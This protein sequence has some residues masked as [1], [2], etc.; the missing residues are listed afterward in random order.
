MRCCIGQAAGGL[1]RQLHN[2]GFVVQLKD[3]SISV[4]GNVCATKKFNA[5]SQLIRDRAT[6]L[7]LQRREKAVSRLQTYLREKKS[8]KESVRTAYSQLDGVDRRISELREVLGDACWFALTNMAR[9][10][11]RAVVVNGISVRVGKD[12]AGRPIREETT[13]PIRIGSLPGVSV[14]QLGEVKR[15][16]EQLRLINI[17]Y[18]DAAKLV[19]SAQVEAKDAEKIS[20]T[21]GSLVSTLEDCQRI[22]ER[23]SAFWK[24]DWSPMI[25][26]V[27]S[28]ESRVKIAEHVLARRGEQSTRRH[29]ARLVQEL[30]H[31]LKSTH[32][33][34]R[35]EVP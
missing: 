31:R 13:T 28:K 9:N 5:K 6:F 2:H 29:A 19:Q 11:T 1:C 10:G 22:V 14:C 27:D 23:D 3:A 35:L 30:E 33:V 34:R 17:A 7:N 20:V 26:L 24:A 25:F 32:G 4:I 12:A 18:E 15:V 21:L 16:K 8:A